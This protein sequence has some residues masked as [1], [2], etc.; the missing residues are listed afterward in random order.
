MAE[1]ASHFQTIHQNALKTGNEATMAAR[2][3]RA[4]ISAFRGLV[5]LTVQTRLF[6]WQI[7]ML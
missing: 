3:F 4:K 5:A 1:I 6:N 2:A 7:I